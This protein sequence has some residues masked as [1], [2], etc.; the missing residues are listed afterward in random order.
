[1]VIY[2]HHKENNKEFFLKKEYSSIMPLM[3]LVV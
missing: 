3:I 2:K 1:M